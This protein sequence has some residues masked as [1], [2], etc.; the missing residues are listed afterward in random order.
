MI[1]LSKCLECLFNRNSKKENNKF[2][3]IY[4]SSIKM[5]VNY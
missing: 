3:L 2:G 1:N 5:N 4:K